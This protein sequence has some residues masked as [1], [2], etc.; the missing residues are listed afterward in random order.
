[1]D[2]VVVMDGP[3]AVNPETDTS[4]ALMLS[5]QQRGHRI[6]HCGAGDIELAENRVW[7]Q[8]RRATAEESSELPLRLGPLER[9]D[10]TAV[11]AV[12]IRTDPPF[13]TQYLHLTLLLDHLVHST[14]V[15][16]SPRG[17]RDANEKLY[18][19]RFPDLAPPMIVTA[20]AP[21]LMAFS[22]MHGAAVLKPIGGHGGRGVMVLRPDDPN[23]PT[24]V[25][26]LTGRGRMPV[27]A[28][29]FL[30]DVVS[31]DKRILLLDGEALGAVLRMP[32]EGDFRANICVGGLTS[33]AEID[34]ADQ[35]IIDQIAPSLV[36]DGLVFVGLDVIDG[37]LTE[38]NVTSPTGIRQLGRL[39]GSRPDHQVIEWLEQAA[40]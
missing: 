2:F 13:D 28:Q 32:A 9:L 11:D 7:A 1:M 3:E 12:L 20:N 37:H 16:N 30:D 15:V 35:R 22:R 17:L 14:L 5:A 27:M 26:T 4:F 31:G 36:A 40:S 6:W 33:T 34:Q 23:A 29:R 18:I 19:C 24:I 25:D 8:A 10:L 38:I 39:T 21:R